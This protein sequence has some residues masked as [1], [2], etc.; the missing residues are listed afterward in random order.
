[1]NNQIGRAFAQIHATDQMRQSAAAC[2]AR[3]NQKKKRRS[4]AV[5]RLAVACGLFLCM[6]I[7]N[8]YVF[9]APVSYISVDINPSV[10]LTLNRL[11]RV[12]AAEGKN[13]DGQRLLADLDLTGKNYLEAVER[14]VESDRLQTYL[15]HDA[16]LIV[17]VASPRADELLLELENSVVTTQYGGTCRRTDLK[18]VPAAHACGLSLGKYEMYTRLSQYDKTITPEICHKMT[19]NQSRPALRIRK[20]MRVV[21]VEAAPDEWLTAIQR[22]VNSVLTNPYRIDILILEFNMQGACLTQEN[23]K[24]E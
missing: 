24:A 10:E 17:A 8:W 9:A 7:G 20:I 16:A 11:N 18:D 4:K 22:M 12:T 13:A 1:M 5:L 23:R 19:M 15:D 6:G 2:I 14:L 3:Y 21:M